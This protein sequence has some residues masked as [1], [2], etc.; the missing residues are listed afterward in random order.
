VV[1]GSW[2]SV[3]LFFLLVAPGLV[4]DLL[5]QR[6]RAGS[7]ESGFREVSRVVLS[8]LASPASPSPSS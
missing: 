1:P 6:R 5:S 4:F 7:P 3:L 8:S 2:L